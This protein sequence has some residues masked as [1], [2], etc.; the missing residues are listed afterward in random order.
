MTLYLVRGLPGSGKSTLAARLARFVIEADD[1]FMQSGEYKFDQSKIGE[2]QLQCRSRVQSLL[3]RGQDVAVAN[4]FSRAW[5][6]QDYVEMAA[7]AL[8]KLYVID[9]YDGGLT[10]EEL[11]ARNAHG[12][13]IEVIQKM[14]ARWEHDWKSARVIA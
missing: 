11:V 1:F 6:L 13:P 10:D 5:E 2:A 3:N 9:L 14:R 8:A 4:T 12:V 7:F